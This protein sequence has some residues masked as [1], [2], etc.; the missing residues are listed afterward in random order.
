MKKVIRIVLTFALVLTVCS[1]MNFGDPNND[2][3]YSKGDSLPNVDGGSTSGGSSSGSNNGSNNNS[4]QVEIGTQ[5][6]SGVDANNRF[7]VTI[8]GDIDE[9]IATLTFEKNEYNWLVHSN[10]KLTIGKLIEID[11]VDNFANVLVGVQQE[12]TTENK[13]MLGVVLV[14]STNTYYYFEIKAVSGDGSGGESLGDSSGNSGSTG[15]FSGNP[16]T[17]EED[18]DSSSG[19]STGDSSS[20]GSS[21]GGSTGDNSS[22]STDG[23]IT[24]GSDDSS[25][26][27]PELNVS[28]NIITKTQWEAFFPERWYVGSFWKS[29]MPVQSF[30]TSSMNVDVYSYENFVAAVDEMKY[31]K[32]KVVAEL[33]NAKK[34]YRMDTRIG[35]WEFVCESDAWSF[36]NST[37]I[38]EF[39]DFINKLGASDEDKKRELCAFLANISHETGE[40]IDGEYQGLF[41]REEIYYQSVPSAI[42]YV[43]D[44]NV[45]YPAVSG[46]SYHGRGPIQLSWNYNYGAVSHILFGDKNTLLSN[47]DKV[48]EDGKIAFMTA[49]WFWMYPQYSKPSCHEVMYS[50]FVANTSLGQQ[51]AWGFGHTIMIINGA[52]ESSSTIARRNAFYTKYKT[53]LNVSTGVGE[54]LNTTGIS[55]Y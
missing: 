24:G 17:P 50:D 4:T 2:P 43:Q 6:G 25:L 45:L 8:T 27:S 54:N 28:A 3:Y 14:L 52:M 15:D 34:I 19:G 21:S 46:Q 44:S 9:I 42:G 26:T 32:L 7:T 29:Y 10:D 35:T 16:E 5:S 23:N 22:G 37:E 38:I 53:T 30:Y 48:M 18:D 47:P 31:I 12:M 13:S 36:D 1:C 11:G 20:G 51:Q 33:Y 49:I 55:P 40:Y 39:N 41:W